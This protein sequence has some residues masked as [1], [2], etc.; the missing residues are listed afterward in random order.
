MERYVPQQSNNAPSYSSVFI[1]ASLRTVQTWC[2]RA[3]YKGPSS[4]SPLIRIR[5]LRPICLAWASPTAASSARPI[6]TL[7]GNEAPLVARTRHAGAQS[8]ATIS[9]W[10]GGLRCVW[11]VKRIGRHLVGAVKHHFLVNRVVG[12]FYGMGLQVQVTVTACLESH[13]SIYNGRFSPG[14]VGGAR[15]PVAGPAAALWLDLDYKFEAR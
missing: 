14:N 11:N 12:G 13:N 8:K 5:S 10:H 7:I 4:R 15:V 6:P 9:K 3:T 1:A 2:I